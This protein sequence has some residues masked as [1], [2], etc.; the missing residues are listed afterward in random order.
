[1]N[2]YKTK[3]S[4]T[5]HRKVHSKGKSAIH[6]KPIQALGEVQYRQLIPAPVD[7]TSAASVSMY[8]HLW[9]TCQ[10]NE[11]SRSMTNVACESKLRS[12]VRF[13]CIHAQETGWQSGVRSCFIPGVPT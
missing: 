9:I 7:R 1:M 5:E 6:T 11:P 8:E 12:V 3:H 4:F 10:K 2:R 13:A